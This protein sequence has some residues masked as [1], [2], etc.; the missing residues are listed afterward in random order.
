[1]AADDRIKCQIVIDKYT[2]DAKKYGSRAQYK[3]SLEVI[4]A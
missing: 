2:L 4:S 1:M 3:H